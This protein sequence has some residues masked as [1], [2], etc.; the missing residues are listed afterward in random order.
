MIKWQVLFEHAYKYFENKCSFYWANQLAIDYAEYIIFGKKQMR[1]K[2]LFGDCY[3]HQ[4][5]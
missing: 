2:E 3:L 1:G 5:F 4:A